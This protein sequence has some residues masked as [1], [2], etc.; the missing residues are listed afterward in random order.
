[1][2]MAVETPHPLPVIGEDQHNEHHS[3]H[4]YGARA[5]D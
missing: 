4:E 2:V 1:M 3:R 5:A